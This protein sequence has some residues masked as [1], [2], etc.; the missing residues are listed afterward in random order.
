MVGIYSIINLKNNKR[1]IGQSVNVSTRIKS[2]FHS[3]A[4]RRHPNKRMQKDYIQ[5][6]RAFNYEILEYNVP[7]HLLNVREKY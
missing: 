6:Y 5:D 1:Y 4:K 3:L 2:H 7:I